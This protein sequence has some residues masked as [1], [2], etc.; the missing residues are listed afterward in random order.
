M[1]MKQIM[2]GL[3][4]SLLLVT[5][6]SQAQTT[7]ED[8]LNQFVQHVE[9]FQAAFEQTVIDPE[10]Q[11]MEQAQGLFV[12]SRPGKFRWDYETPYPQKIVADGKNIW[13]YDVD[14]EQVTV[15]SQQEALAET[16]AT[17]L[18]GELVPE[19]KYNINNLPSDDGLLW[20]ELTPKQ[21]ESNFQAV[22][23]A[24][25]GDVLQ[26]MIMRDSFDQ[27]TRLTFTQVIENPKFK[28]DMFKFTPPTGIDVVGEAQQ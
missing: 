24:F 5:G 14:L 20:V 27:R 19:D 16:P 13:F 15:K 2:A 23:L 12:L 10:G 6:L 3:F 18:S 28:Q 11:V 4:L 26:Q 8:K 21:T 1:T 9:T 7:G 22:T 17:L 25:D